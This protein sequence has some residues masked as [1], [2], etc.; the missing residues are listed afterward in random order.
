MKRSILSKK[1]FWF[2]RI[3]NSSAENM[4]LISS[5]SGLKKIRVALR[6]DAIYQHN[7]YEIV[8]N[9]EICDLHL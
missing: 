7:A 2:F 5:T 3:L 6:G 9:N 8:G 1:V 4:L